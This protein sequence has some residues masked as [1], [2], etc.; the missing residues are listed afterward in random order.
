MLKVIMTIPDKYENIY[1]E[2]KL[3]DYFNAFSSYNPSASAVFGDFKE[4]F[5]KSHIYTKE[6]KDEPLSEYPDI[7]TVEEVGEILRT[8]N[9]SAIMRLLKTGEIKAL[10]IGST[11]RIP[12]KNLIAFIEA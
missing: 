11:Y 10:K 5:D 9:H 12:K 3:A 4:I 2:N 7:L 6:G 1:K 8:V